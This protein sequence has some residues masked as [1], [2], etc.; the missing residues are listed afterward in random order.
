MSRAYKEDVATAGGV[1]E[2]PAPRRLLH[3]IYRI[4]VFFSAASVVKKFSLTIE[5]NSFCV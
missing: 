3:S 5:I 1:Q 2:F 4:S